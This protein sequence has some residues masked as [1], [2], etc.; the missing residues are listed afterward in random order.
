[1]VREKKP[2]KSKGKAWPQLAAA[3]FC[4]RILEETP[5]GVLSA[6]RIVDQITIAVPPELEG[7]PVF[8]PV[9]GLIAFK[10]GEASGKHAL[11]LVRV[12][13]DCNYKLVQASRLS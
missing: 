4:D 6:I 1:M 10:S 11:R 12:R 8:I 9:S 3:F 13:L 2:A 7:H 5:D